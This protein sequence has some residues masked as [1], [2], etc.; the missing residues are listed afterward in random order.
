[1]SGKGN[2]QAQDP[3]TDSAATEGST[4]PG[5]TGVAS[6]RSITP[7]GTLFTNLDRQSTGYDTGTSNRT[8]DQSTTPLVTGGSAMSRSFR[9]PFGTAHTSLRN[10]QAL[11]TQPSIFD[12]PRLIAHDRRGASRGISLAETAREFASFHAGAAPSGHHATED[13][14]LPREARQRRQIWYYVMCCL[15]ILPFVAPL[16]YCGVLDAALSWCTRGEA[17]RL[18][19]KQRGRILF[20][21]LSALIFWLCIVGAVTAV[22]WINNAHG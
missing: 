7:K 3:P 14:H 10:N 11:P 8:S 16:V 13:G 21:G 19:P 17:T 4:K 22:A 6:Q 20:L 5:H 12:S 18:S 1:M 9:N 2:P 15:S